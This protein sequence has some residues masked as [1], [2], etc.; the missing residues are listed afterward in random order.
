MLKTQIK[1]M[2]LYVFLYGRYANLGSNDHMIKYIKKTS[3]NK[4]DIKDLGVAD[5]ILEKQILRHLMDR[6]GPNLIMLKKFSRNFL[7]VI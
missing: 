1:F 4:F 6:Y 2:S 7:K 3:T 5:V